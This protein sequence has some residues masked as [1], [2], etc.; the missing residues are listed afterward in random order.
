[1]GM[2]I[3]TGRESRTDNERIAEKSLKKNYKINRYIV[4]IRCKK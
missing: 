4:E 3:V 1:M 2:G